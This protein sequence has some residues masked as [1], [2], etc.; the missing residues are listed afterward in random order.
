M[1][2]IK[3]K[4]PLFNT[5]RSSLYGNPGGFGYE[6]QA[7]AKDPISKIPKLNGTSTSSQPLFLI[8]SS[9]QMKA[10]YTFKFWSF[11]KEIGVLINHKKF[12]YYRERCMCDKRFKLT[13]GRWTHLWTSGVR[14]K[15]NLYMNLLVELSTQYLFATSLS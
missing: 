7:W 11:K 10:Y 3:S 15:W 13:G 4:K 14:S 2:N 8:G 5:P 9:S 12:N 1:Q 6:M